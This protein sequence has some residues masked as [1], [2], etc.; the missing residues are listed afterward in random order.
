M[1]ESFRVITFSLCDEPRKSGGHG[2]SPVTLDDFAAQVASALDSRQIERAAICGVSFGGLIALRFAAQRS[3]RTEALI[4]ASTPGPQWRLRPMHEICARWPRLCAPIFFAGVPGRLRAEI[5]RAIPDPA[6]RR[7]FRWQQLA[8]LVRAPV[9]PVRMGARA[10]LIGAANPTADCS[11]IAAPTLVISGEPQLDHVVS[12]GGT[13]E[14][15][16]LIVG[17]QLRVLECTGHLGC[18]TRPHAFTEIVRDFL[19]TTVPE[20]HYAA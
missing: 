17:A 6:M 1:A 3:K 19:G 11:Q 14:Y 2:L 5:A 12:V 8:T 15:Q 20:Q 18:L 7:S 10:K 9:S 4:L 16:R 13:H